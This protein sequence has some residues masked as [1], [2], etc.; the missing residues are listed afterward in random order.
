M[1]W[2][3]LI[4]IVLS[5]SKSGSVGESLEAETSKRKERNLPLLP[6]LNKSTFSQRALSNIRTQGFALC[7]ECMFF[8]SFFF[9]LV[10]F[11]GDLSCWN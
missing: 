10:S 11:V 2:Q 5:A 8:F 7:F 6:Q 9:C 1:F 4:Y 3:L